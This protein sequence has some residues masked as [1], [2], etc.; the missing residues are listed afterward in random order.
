[1]RTESI[2]NK[3]FNVDE[4]KSETKEI[5][6]FTNNDATTSRANDGTGM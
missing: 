4:R 6:K 5:S 3:N 2:D 1:V